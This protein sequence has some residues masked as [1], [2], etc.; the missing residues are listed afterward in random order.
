[1]GYATII[2][3]TLSAFAMAFVGFSLL[4]LRANVQTWV[5]EALDDAVRRQDDR[6][7]QRVDRAAET[8]LARQE[9]I[10]GDNP[11]ER[12]GQPFG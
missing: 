9:A 7:R 12:I 10:D 3:M 6:I 4:R 2:V 11:F 5:A 8:A 1:M